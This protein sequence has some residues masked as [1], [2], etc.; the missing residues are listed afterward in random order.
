M[1]K[2]SKLNT[3]LLKEEINKRKSQRR[4]DCYSI[5]QENVSE[6]PFMA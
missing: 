4:K 1:S 2:D 5:I 3:Q 6:N